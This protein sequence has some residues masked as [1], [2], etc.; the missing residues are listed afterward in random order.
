MRLLAFV[1]ASN[2]VTENISSYTL[3]STG[4]LKID[5]YFSGDEKTSEVLEKIKASC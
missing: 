2:P 5:K 1:H 3:N 4:M